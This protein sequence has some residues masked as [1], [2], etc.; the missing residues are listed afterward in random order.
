MDDSF[1][2]LGIESA[3]VSYLKTFCNSKLLFPTKE[4]QLQLQ[5]WIY[6]AIKKFLDKLHRHKRSGKP[7]MPFLG[8]RERTSAHTGLG[9]LR[10][11]TA[12]ERKTRTAGED[13]P[14]R[15]GVAAVEALLLH[16]TAAARRAPC[17]SVAVVA[18]EQSRVLANDG[19]MERILA[20][21]LIAVPRYG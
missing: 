16:R 15:H 18:E 4:R 8:S 6:C 14:R 3:I 13:S 17:C 19:D 10:G 11:E 2:S 20:I 7:V 9:R 21:F 5:T 12:W 1:W